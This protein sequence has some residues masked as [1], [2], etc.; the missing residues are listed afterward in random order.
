M[1]ETAASSRPAKAMA[2]AIAVM[3]VF[4][5]INV[6]NQALSAAIQTMALR[7]LPPTLPT[8]QEAKRGQQHRSLCSK[9]QARGRALAIVV[10]TCMCNEKQQTAEDA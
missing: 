10:Y 7:V 9:A 8:L 4:P 3:T 2:A 1:L 5:Q 6:A